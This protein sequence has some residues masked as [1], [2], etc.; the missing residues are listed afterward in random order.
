LS[1]LIFLNHLLT[2]ESGIDEAHYAWYIDNWN[3][4]SLDYFLTSSPGNIIRNIV[5]GEPLRTRLT[6]AE[7]FSAIG[8]VEYFNPLSIGSLRQMK[9]RS[10][11]PWG[12]IGYQLGEQALFEC[13][14]YLP[15]KEKRIYDGELLY[16]DVFYSKLSDSN[17]ANG[18]RKKEFL[19]K[20]KTPLF[21]AQDVNTWEGS[22]SGKYDIHTI[23]DLYTPDKQNLVVKDLINFNYIKLSSILEKHSIKLQSL[24]GKSWHSDIEGT[25]KGVKVDF[26]FSG[27]L[28]C[29]HL[30]GYE[31]TANLLLKDEMS[32]DE[33]KTSILKY[34]YIFRGYDVSDLIV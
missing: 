9:Y 4:K 27:M 28:A 30:C 32:F 13:G 21:I 34:M 6:V 14:I 20:D 10:I 25:E 29:C 11:N 18:L 17:W 26:S 23:S 2:Y 3:K 12:F 16:L 1:S 15:K 33:I 7:Y 19:S 31:A 8:V 24:E 22:F 5:T